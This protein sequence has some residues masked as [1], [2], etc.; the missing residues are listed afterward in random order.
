MIS[1]YIFKSDI[2][3]DSKKFL[4]KVFH[5]LI[6]NKAHYNPN[7]LYEDFNKYFSSEKNSN[8]LDD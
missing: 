2:Y 3:I 4:F 5:K 8:I 1:N 6:N 7:E